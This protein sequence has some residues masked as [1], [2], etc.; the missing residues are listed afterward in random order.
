M[1]VLSLIDPTA[2]SNRHIGIGT[3][4]QRYV[5]NERTWKSNA[6]KIMNAFGSIHDP[7]EYQF[8]R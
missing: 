2:G 6:D 3:Q 1:N 8:K 5:L 4:L 7:K